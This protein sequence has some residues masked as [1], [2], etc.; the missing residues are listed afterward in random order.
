MLGS[1]IFGHASYFSDL[2]SLV[3]LVTGLIKGLVHELQGHVLAKSRITERSLK[4]VLKLRRFSLN[5]KQ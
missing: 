5:M 1:F 2:T 3:Q 4:K